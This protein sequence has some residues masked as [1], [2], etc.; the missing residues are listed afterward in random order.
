MSW[1]R[2]VK[3]SGS[4][5]S[6]VQVAVTVPFSFQPLELGPVIVRADTKKGR[7]RRVARLVVE[8]NMTG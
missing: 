2:I 8:K 3:I 1:R 5:E 4:P 7:A 6:V